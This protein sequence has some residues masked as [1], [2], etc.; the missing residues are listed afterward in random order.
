MDRSEC[1]YNHRRP[2]TNIYLLIYLRR[3]LLIVHRKR[4]IY[5]QQP[6]YSNV[7][8]PSGTGAPIMVSASRDN[9]TAII[10]L[11]LVGVFLVAYRIHHRCRPGKTKRAASHQYWF[12]QTDSYSGDARIYSVSTTITGG[13]MSL[14]S[15][16]RNISVGSYNGVPGQQSSPL[17]DG[18]IL[19]TTTLAQHIDCSQDHI[20]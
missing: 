19:I 18:V 16:F 9:I 5:Q 6:T 2:G 10:I 20:V 8:C 14:D 13:R 3:G 1:I 17:G 7:Q 11:V 12:G 15:V 4:F